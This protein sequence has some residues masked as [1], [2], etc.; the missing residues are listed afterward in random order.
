ML[1]LAYVERISVTKGKEQQAVNKSIGW[2]ADG[3]VIVI[4]ER[5]HLTK[6]WLPLFLG[7]TKFSSFT[8]KMYR[9]GFRKTYPPS[10]QQESES[11]I[12]FAND[13][14]Q[15]DD[16]G[17]LSKMNSTT[18]QKL[19]TRIARSGE[20][21]QSDKQDSADAP[22]KAQGSMP[23][24]HRF[25]SLDGSQHASTQQGLASSSNDKA[26]TN[27]SAFQS[28]IGNE[29]SSGLHQQNRVSLLD[30]LVSA[31]RPTL[32]QH[33]H[34]TFMDHSSTLRA[35]SDFGDRPTLPESQALR[36]S[37]LDQAIQ[38]NVQNSDLIELLRLSSARREDQV[39]STELAF[40]QLLQNSQNSNS[41]IDNSLNASS[42]LEGLIPSVRR[43][44][45]RNIPAVARLPTSEPPLEQARR[46]DSLLSSW[47]GPSSSLSQL[48]TAALAMN[49]AS[50]A[51]LSVQSN[52]S[53]LE[54]LLQQQQLQQRQQQQE[55]SIQRLLNPRS[56]FAALQP[57]TDPNMLSE[58]EQLEALAEWIRRNQDQLPRR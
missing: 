28:L 39:R 17:L 35:T 26:E 3:K 27:T 25:N 38:G 2:T 52:D 14:F 47:Q 57:R 20:G 44:D 51:G 30:R 33:A 54:S 13:N 19:R 21:S 53:L 18:A 9:W 16:I 4:R 40:S 5:E 41:A 10:P 15:R 22:Q 31:P 43:P 23:L 24:L 50:A 29:V 1:L 12:F 6:T 11:A 7:D 46:L 45:I 48:P 55:E 36:Y 8:R 49:L 32:L 56:N 58:Q 34:R 42:L 37:A